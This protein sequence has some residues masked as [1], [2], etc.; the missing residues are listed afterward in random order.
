MNLALISPRVMN[1]LWSY[2]KQSNECFIRFQDTSKL[3][4]K[5]RLPLL[6]PTSR[7]RSLFGN[8][9]NRSSSCYMPTYTL[10]G[11]N[12]GQSLACKERKT[13]IVFLCQYDQKENRLGKVRSPPSSLLDH[14]ILFRSRYERSL[15]SSE[16]RTLGKGCEGWERPVTFF[17][18]KF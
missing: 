7:S 8:W 15:S 11:Y 14:P 4:E 6:Q 5:T 10:L 18:Y 3:L 12:H 2:V 1:G 17:M 9:M 13:Y 16:E